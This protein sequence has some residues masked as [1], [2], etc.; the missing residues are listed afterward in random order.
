MR[1][2][3]FAPM[4]WFVMAP[5]NEGSPE[6]SATGLGPSL[7]GATAAAPAA[8]SPDL[9]HDQISAPSNQPEQARVAP[10]S[11]STPSSESTS[12]GVP[13][14]WRQ[15]MAAGD[16]AFLKTLERFENP[17]ALAKAYKELSSK[18][19]A[20]EIRAF[21]GPPNDATPEQTAAWRTAHGLPED[22]S[23]YLE[24]VPP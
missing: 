19:S 10:P 5:Q 4:P 11:K 6:H 7:G 8:V 17:A 9:P 2:V 15:D 18:L 22:A 1:L 21:K 24:Q 14:D 13:G 20:G 12:K 16:R 3:R 23:A